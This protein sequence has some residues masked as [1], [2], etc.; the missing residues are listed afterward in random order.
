MESACRALVLLAASAVAEIHH[1]TWDHK[2]HFRGPPKVYDSAW[3]EF[4]EEAKETGDH[5]TIYIVARMTPAF[6]RTSLYTNARALR[7]NHPRPA[8]A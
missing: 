5:I 1:T 7:R 2:T 8:R 3:Q 6:Y 4:W